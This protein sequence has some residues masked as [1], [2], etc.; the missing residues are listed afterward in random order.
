MTPKFRLV[1]SFYP[2]LK[3]SPLTYYAH[4]WA[5]IFDTYKEVL[6][7]QLSLILCFG[8]LI[9]YQEPDAHII[10]RNLSSDFLN[11]NVIK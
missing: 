8:A 5:I 4:A 7:S 3:Q 9:G 6:I 10:S 11:A 1:D 2:Q